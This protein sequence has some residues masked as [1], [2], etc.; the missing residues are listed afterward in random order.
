MNRRVTWTVIF[1]L[2]FYALHSAIFSVSLGDLSQ[3]LRSIQSERIKATLDFLASDHFDGRATGTEGARLTVAYLASVFQRNGLQPLGKGNAGFYQDFELS[4]AL[5]RSGCTLQTQSQGA[6]ITS[7][8]MGEDFTPTPWGPDA[9]AGPGECVFVGYGISAPEYHYDDYANV[10]VNDK[11]VVFLSKYP[12]NEKSSPFSGLSQKNY[13][14][15]MEK[16]IQAEKLGASGVIIILPQDEELPVLN[17]S[18]F[19]KAKVY[20]ASEVESIRIPS[21]FVSYKTGEKIVEQESENPPKN[22]TGVKNSIDDRL[23]PHSFNLGERAFIK[24]LYERKKLVG[25][26]VIGVLPGSDAALA[27]EYIILGAHHDHLGEGEN[28]EIFFGA[29]DD[30]SGTTGLLELSEAFQRNPIKPKRSILFAAWGAEEIGL[31]GS[32]HYVKNPLV[33]LQS[34]V[35]MLQMDM[36]GRN[37][38]REANP[39][40]DIQEEKPERNYN[41]VSVNGSPFSHDLRQILKSSN[42]QVGLELKF[43]YDFGEENLIKRSDHWPFLEQGIPSL[44][45]FTGFHPDYHKPTDTADKIN[46][47]KMAKVLKLIYLTTWEISEQFQGPR[48]SSGPFQHDAGEY[49]HGAQSP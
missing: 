26:N 8:K 47:E 29:D 40:K 17:N 45:L 10:A 24:T 18:D 25:Q 20:L 49:K 4:Q 11:V 36:I 42:R 46:F 15:S 9:P 44:L 34:T 1:V 32:R 43:R 39:S 31:L 22:L 19:K 41:S 38:E 35:A 14:D 13:D 2:T 21:V 12:A 7:F 5:P 37:E 28:H 33:P 27:K 48:F 30:A 6:E 23:K 16:A 3:G